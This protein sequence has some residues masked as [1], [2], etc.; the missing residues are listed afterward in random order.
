MLYHPVQSACLELMCFILR[1]DAAILEMDLAAVLCCLLMRML[2]ALAETSLAQP[3]LASFAPTV[4]DV[5]S[6]IRAPS[7]ANTPAKI[8]PRV[9]GQPLENLGACVS[10][11]TNRS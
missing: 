7:E 6:A 4:V 9:L 10:R 3:G 8:L 11:C 1:R 2:L 5:A